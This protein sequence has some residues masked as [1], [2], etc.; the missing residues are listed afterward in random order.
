[1][2]QGFGPESF[3]LKEAKKGFYF[4]KIKYFG[5]RKQKIETPTF[6]KVTIY[7]NQGKVNEEKKVYVV[8][9]S[10]N[11]SEEVIAKIEF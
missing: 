6:M 3:T 2:T 10:K 8:R 5:D 7:K 9:L 1:M 4:I 11:D